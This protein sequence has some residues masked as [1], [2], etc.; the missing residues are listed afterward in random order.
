MGNPLLF[1]ETDFTVGFADPM[2]PIRYATVVELRL[3][4]MGDFYEKLHFTMEN[5][6]FRDAVKWR[7]KILAPNYRKAHP[8]AK[9]GRT[10]RLAYVA[11]TLFASIRRREK[12]VPEYRHWKI[13]S[14][15]NRDV[16][17]TYCRKRCSNLESIPLSAPKFQRHAAYAISRRPPT[18]ACRDTLNLVTITHAR[19]LKFNMLIPA[20]A[21]HCIVDK[22]VIRPTSYL[23][24][25][26]S[27][28]THLRGYCE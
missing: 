14:S 4:Q 24:V 1:G 22:Y 21:Q 12:N 26:I 11:V 3:Q 25:L 10:N 20:L 18:V 7:V 19:K 27:R 6:K 15:I 9:S 5:F 28:I 23:L 8:Y 13:E 2:F 17:I 16:V